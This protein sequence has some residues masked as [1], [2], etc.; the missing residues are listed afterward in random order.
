MKTLTILTLAHLL[1]IVA[2]AKSQDCDCSGYMTEAMLTRV[3]NQQFT[4]NQEF[5]SQFMS[6]FSWNEWSKIKSTNKSKAQDISASYK[7]YFSGKYNKQDLMNVS[8]TE[9]S[10]IIKSLRND[11]VKNNKL[12][13]QSEFVTRYPSEALINGHYRCIELC[14][15]KDLEMSVTLQKN[16]NYQLLI[17][18]YHPRMVEVVDSVLLVNSEFI[19]IG[20]TSG[21]RITYDSKPAAYLLKLSNPEKNGAFSVKF[22]DKE[23][24][25]IELIIPKEQLEVSP[26]KRD[27]ESFSCESFDPV[28]AW[29]QYENK[30]G[31]GNYVIGLYGNNG[32]RNF[33]ARNWLVCG[34]LEDMG[35]TGKH[36][37]YYVINGLDGLGDGYNWRNYPGIWLTKDDF[38]LI[39]KNSDPGI[40]NPPDKPCEQNSYWVRLNPKFLRIIS[41][42]T[43]WLAPRSGADQFV[44]DLNQYQGFQM[45][46]FWFD[47]EEVSRN[48]PKPPKTSIYIQTYREL[49]H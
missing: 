28:K 45:E 24:I 21:H 36:Q 34:Y 16:G 5:F 35:V 31:L 49:L 47:I 12:I 37:F 8:E 42:K 33:A 13:S 2:I 19:G 29:S 39:F 4:D 10:S 18:N 40:N 20:L 23:P 26:S 22:Q 44:K 32:N 3:N 6:N 48:A 7:K 30:I 11:L 15:S 46:H 9:Y 17:R 43:E 38:E 1:F 14:G 25:T 27:N 41:D